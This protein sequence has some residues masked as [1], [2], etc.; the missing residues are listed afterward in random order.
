M[1]L[2]SLWLLWHFNRDTQPR[3]LAH[4]DI[5]T[6]YTAHIRTYIY[7]YIACMFVHWVQPKTTEQ[8]VT[9]V[10]VCF[11]HTAPIVAA[12]PCRIREPLPPVAQLPCQISL[13]LVHFYRVK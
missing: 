6:I 9:D 7:R 11:C 3:T 13:F 2:G 1:G 10:F 12:A 5:Y 4:I 8:S